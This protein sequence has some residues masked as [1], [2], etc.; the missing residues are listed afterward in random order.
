[1]VLSSILFWSLDL[2]SDRLMT[3]TGAEARLVSEANQGCFCSFESALESGSRPASSPHSG[4]PELRGTSCRVGSP[5][6][7]C[8]PILRVP[9]DSYVFQKTKALFS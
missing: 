7:R 2:P 4:H 3:K 5:V 6:V 1:M 8:Q 9:I